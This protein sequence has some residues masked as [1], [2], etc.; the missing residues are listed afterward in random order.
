MTSHF[1][2]SALFSVDGMVAVV[3]GGGSG[4]GLTMAQS[5]ATNGAKKVYILGRR[6][7]VLNTAAQSHPSIL[8]PIQCDVTSKDSL[9]S[10][11]DQ[12]TAETGYINLLIANSGI[13]GQTNR[14]DWT[15]TKPIAE[16][17]AELF[18]KNSMEAFTDVFHV[19]VTGAFFT[20]IAFLELLDAGNKRAVAEGGFGA[21][22]KPGGKVPIV[23]S[24][25]I[26]TS[27]IS[28]F[29]RSGISAPQYTASKAAV[30]QLVRQASTNLAAY[31]IR[32]NALAPGLFPSEMAQVIMATRK[33][34][35]EGPDNA[36]FIPAKRFGTEEEMAGTLLFLAS[37]AGAY[38]NG[39]YIVNDGG[40]L[41]VMPSGY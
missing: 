3:T 18:T 36:L 17:R 2:A 29:S 38:C 26:V 28:A 9:Q 35:E 24:Q 33:P 39:S 8:V 30:L 27:S 20:L 23:Q 15:F 1:E 22:L 12:I 4:I 37:R 16:V 10:A 5:L 21:P 40:R 19:N 6:L 7:D 31:G 34:E 25:V 32:V 41:A 11:V 14:W 13:L